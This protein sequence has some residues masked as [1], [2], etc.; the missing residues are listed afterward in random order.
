MI[1]R[2]LC[3]K[4]KFEILCA[5]LGIYHCHCSQCRKLTGTAF[6]TGCITPPETFKWLSGETSISTYND[7]SGYRAS[8]CNNCGSSVPNKGRLPFMWIPAGTIEQT[9]KLEVKA[10]L[11]VASKA[12]WDRIPQGVMKFETMPNLEEMIGLLQQ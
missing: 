3:G 12:D 10:H 5:K 7:H 6:N 2:C 4:V 11:F 9:D 1:G 8:F